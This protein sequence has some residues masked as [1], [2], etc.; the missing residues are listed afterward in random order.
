M[1]TLATERVSHK[2]AEELLTQVKTES[3]RTTPMPQINRRSKFKSQSA[4]K[5]N[6]SLSKY[7]VKTSFPRQESPFDQSDTSPIGV[8]HL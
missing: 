8:Y 2:N 3:Q 7:A 6:Q 5:Q 4:K 1:R